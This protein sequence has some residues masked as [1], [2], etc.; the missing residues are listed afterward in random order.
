MKA[1]VLSIA[2]AT[3]TASSALADGFVCKNEDLAV[4]VYNNTEAKVGTRTAA[5]MVISDRNVAYGRKTIARFTDMNGRISQKGASY[6][7]D[8]DLRYSNS[9]R[10]GELIGG[11]KLGELHTIQL[12]VD[13]SYANPIPAGELVSG[14][15]TLNKRNGDT[16]TLDLECERYLKN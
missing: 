13:F 9:S 7:A 10:K 8:V 16:I 6:L 4:K 11:T 12:D 5:V 2:L 14:A 1:L 3:A 15:L